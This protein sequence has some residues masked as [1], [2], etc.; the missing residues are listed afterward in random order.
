LFTPDAAA[1]ARASFSELIERRRNATHLP[2][3]LTVP[4]HSERIQ[5]AY[6][7]PVKAFKASAFTVKS[8]KRVGVVAMS[9]ATDDIIEK[10]KV[11]TVS[12][13]S[14]RSRFCWGFGDVVCSAD[15]WRSRGRH[16]KRHENN[17]C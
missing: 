4:T 8:A 3:S 10:M 11:L 17:V 12:N 1:H 7:A 9:A 16:A 13:P 2:P 15:G 6:G 14:P 5:I